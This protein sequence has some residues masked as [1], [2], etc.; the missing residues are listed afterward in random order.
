MKRYRSP[1]MIIGML[2]IVIN[3]IVNR[4]ITPLP[5]AVEIPML[6]LGIALLVIGRFWKGPR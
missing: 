5:E 3:I 2:I 1:I 6:L 4:F